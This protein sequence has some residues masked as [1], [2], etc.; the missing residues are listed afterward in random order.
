MHFL[1]VFFFVQEVFQSDK[2]VYLSFLSIWILSK[3][4]LHNNAYARATLLS[5]KWNNLKKQSTK[6]KK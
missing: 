6:L 1:V 5:L 2:L 3:M 4:C